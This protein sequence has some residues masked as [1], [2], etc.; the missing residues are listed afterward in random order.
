[1]DLFT[2]ILNIHKLQIQQSLFV[3]QPW[4]PE[5][6]V[7]LQDIPVN[8]KIRNDNFT[9]FLD[10]VEIESLLLRLESRNT[11]LRDICHLI[12]EHAIENSKFIE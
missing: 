4:T 10:V 9:Y 2:A 1:M 3:E 5:S 7:K 6:L 12:I 8:R 11:C